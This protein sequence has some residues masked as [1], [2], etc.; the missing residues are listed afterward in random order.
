MSDSKDSTVTYTAVSSPFEGLSDI[1]S[2]GVDGLPVMPEDPYTYVVAAFQVPPSPN[3]VPGPEQAPPLLVYVPYVLEPVY[4]KFMPPK[5]EVLPVE[6]QPLHAAVSP[7]ADSPGYILESD[8]EEDPEEDPIDYPAN[9]GDDDD[10]DDES[11]DDDEDDDDDDVEEDVDEDKEEG[12]ENLAS[13]DSVPPPVHCVTARMSIREQPPMP[14]WSEAEVDRLLAICTPPPSSLTPLSSPLPQKPSPPLRVSLPLPVSPPPI[15]SPTHPLR[16]R[17]AMIRLR[18]KAPSTPHPPPLGTPPSGTPPLLPIPAPT[19]SPSLLLPS[20]DHGADKPEVCL[21][22]RKR[23]CFAFG[24][25]YEVGESSSAPA[26]RPTRD[27]WDEMLEE[28]PGAPATDET[29]LGRR[30]T[31]FLTTVRHDTYEIYVRLGDAQDERLSREAWS[32][33]MEA[34]DTVRAEVMSLRITVLA[35]QSEIAALRAADR[36]RQAQLAE[37]LRLM[38]TL[39][40]QVTTLQSQRGP[41]SGPTQPDVPEDAA[42]SS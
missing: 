21:P 2:S 42:S 5:D 33:S 38:S 11:S 14:F 6:E 24:P 36:T 39:Q 3:Y 10:D 17:V 25:G 32:Q 1:G 34:S 18:A 15:A 40:A 28:M 9:G 12:E 37:T 27:T 31:N 16:Y 35:Q 19:S 23:L 26:A 8:P 29:E 7:T 30:M 13:A 20:T 22:P 4:S 41:A